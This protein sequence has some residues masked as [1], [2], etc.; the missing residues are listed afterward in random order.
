MSATAASPSRKPSRLRFALF[1]FAG[2][3]PL[4]TFLIYVLAPF[5]SGWAIWQR[6]LIM[7]PLIVLVMNFAI[8]PFIHTRCRR[9]I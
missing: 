3:Y 9:W 5:T 7:V 6:N 2:V 8:I 1:V 4:V